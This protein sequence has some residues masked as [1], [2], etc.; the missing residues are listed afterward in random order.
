MPYGIVGVDDTSGETIDFQWFPTVEER[1]K[2]FTET[3]NTN[4]E[5]VE[6]KNN[7]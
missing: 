4:S 6:E 3:L 7:D 1:D 5:Y 2:E